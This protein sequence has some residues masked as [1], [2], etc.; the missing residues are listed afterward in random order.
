MGHWCRICRKNKPNEKFSGKGHKNH[1]CKRCASK[2]KDKI[3][4]IDL[5]EEIFGYLKQSH[6]STK[7]IKRLQKLS[8]LQ[9]EDQNIGIN[10]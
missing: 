5:K 6:I 4:E 9:N 1:I 3:D 10:L 8:T 7:N 2:P